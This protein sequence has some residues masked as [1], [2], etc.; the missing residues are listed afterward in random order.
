MAGRGA[1][2]L[3]SV[4]VVAS[5][6]S[7]EVE[8][9]EKCRRGFA[10]WWASS[11]G[12][13]VGRRLSSFP[14]FEIRWNDGW[15]T[16]SPTSSSRTPGE[17]WCVPPIDL[18][19]FSEV[20]GGCQSRICA[21]RFC[22]NSSVRFWPPSLLVVKALRTPLTLFR[23][24]SRNAQVYSRQPRASP[25]RLSTLRSS[26]TDLHTP[27]LHLDPIYT[28]A[29]QRRLSPPPKPIHEPRHASSIRSPNRCN[30]RISSFLP[31]Q[32]KE[33]LTD[34]LVWEYL[35]R[36]A[37]RWET[38]EVAEGVGEEGGDEGSCSSGLVK[39]RRV[40]GRN[41]PV[42]MKRK[43]AYHPKRVV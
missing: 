2:I 17:G 23:Q 29:I 33:Q 21:W 7:S 39:R 1:H 18:N 27:L 4:S 35:Q 16:V 5:S 42:R 11:A 37:E 38:H 8:E 22:R 10:S 36:P 3:E 25:S 32:R 6:P 34:L 26:L 30:P 41:G 24:F 9:G 14:P 19:I 31:S 12:V 13:G 40:G 28:T 20:E 15:S 43:E